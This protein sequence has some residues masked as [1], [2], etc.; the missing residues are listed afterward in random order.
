MVPPPTKRMRQTSEAQVMV[1]KAALTPQ[2]NQPGEPAVP[3]DLTG[4]TPTLSIPENNTGMWSPTTW[5]SGDHNS[6]QDGASIDWE[7][8][9]WESYSPT[10]PSLTLSPPRTFQDQS[11]HDA[12]YVDPIFR[13]KLNE[14]FGPV[15]P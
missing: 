13:D 2:Q 6:A 7:A 8:L 1:N 14:L 9:L 10:R 3:I 12:D 11:D 15:S 4:D 5:L